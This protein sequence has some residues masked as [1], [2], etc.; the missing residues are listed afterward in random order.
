MAKLDSEPLETSAKRTFQ[1][2]LTLL[3]FLHERPHP[4]EELIARLDEQGL[5]DYDRFQNA[6]AI[7]SHNKQQFTRDRNYLK[8]CSYDVRCDRSTGLYLWHNS[9]F[10]LSLTPP[11]LE[12]FV[13]LL[14]T[15]DKTMILHS[16]DLQDLLGHL[17]SLLP[18]DQ[19]KI[20]VNRRRPFSINLHETTDYRQADPAT[21]AEIERAIRNQQQL[22][23]RY[24]PSRD[25]REK[26]HI[27]EPR[28]L[29]FENGHVYFRG[30]SLKWAKEWSFRLDYVVPGSAKM[31]HDRI[32]PARPS[33]P[34]YRLQY[35]LSPTIARHKVSHR[36]EGQQVERHP[37]GSATV[38][39]QIT[40]LFAARRL[41]IAY[42]DH[43]RVISPPELV[44]QMQEA[45]TALHNMYSNPE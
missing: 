33:H 31:L 40:D 29:V 8:A 34:V 19:R 11:Q 9:H 4:Y 7:A 1:R 32:V 20:V 37:D 6:D 3:G 25:G 22:E 43:C 23:F 38:T 24:N 12:A 27:V 2:R 5:L 41:L 13:L 45:I 18:P 15:F 26:H 44:S 42:F 30:Y 39:A 14:N 10:G 21:V 28:P 36:F 35:W 17:T 16:G